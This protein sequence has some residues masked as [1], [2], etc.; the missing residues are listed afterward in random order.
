MNDTYMIWPNDQVER[1]NPDGETTEEWSAPGLF[2]QLVLSG[3]PLHKEPSGGRWDG[4]LDLR[5]GD[6][7]KTVIVHTSGPELREHELGE[8]S[9]LFLDWLREAYR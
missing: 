4:V 5:V 8:A 9:S 3:Y 6:D 1:I 2:A 7:E